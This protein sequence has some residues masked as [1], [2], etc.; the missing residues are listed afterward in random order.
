MGSQVRLKAQGL[1]L[2]DRLSLR[3]HLD[4]SFTT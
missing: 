4:N 2:G 3:G 1:G